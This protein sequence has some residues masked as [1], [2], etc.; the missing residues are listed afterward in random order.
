M[1]ILT[2][3][4]KIH[5]REGE[6]TEGQSFVRI[7]LEPNIGVKTTNDIKVFDMKE[8]ILKVSE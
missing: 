5:I 8:E 6:D 3:V 7:T 1:K 4:G 2:E